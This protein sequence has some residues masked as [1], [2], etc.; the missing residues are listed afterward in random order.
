[1]GL[2]VIIRELMNAKKL[3][4]YELASETG[5]SQASLSRILN[6]ET[7]KLNLRNMQLLANYFNVSLDYLRTGRG[8][9]KDN[10]APG[11][12]YPV[13]SHEEVLSRLVITNEKLVEQNAELIKALTLQ[14]LTI[15]KNAETINTLSSVAHYIGENLPKKA[16]GGIAL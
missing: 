4:A 15:N 9:I 5:I 8:Q 13:L 14:T 6:S 1:M 2:G 3:T 12:A 11:V 7:N 10:P 16:R